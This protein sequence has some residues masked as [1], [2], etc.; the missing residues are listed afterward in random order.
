MGERHE[1]KWEMGDEA[2]KVGDQVPKIESGRWES[3]RKKVGD[4]R[5]TNKVGENFTIKWEM[6][7]SAIKKVGDG[8]LHTLIHPPPL[9]IPDFFSL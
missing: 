8:I 4:G 2:L 7:G 1:K 3:K 5:Q 6:G 9:N